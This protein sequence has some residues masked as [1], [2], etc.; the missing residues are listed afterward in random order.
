[1]SSVILQRK[2][3][4]AVRQFRILGSE[5]AAGIATESALIERAVELEVLEGAARR[6]AGGSGAVV[7]LEA[8][9]GLGKTALLES[10]A[11]FAAQAGCLVR[12]AAPSPL[13]RHFPFG[14]V[15]ALLEAPLRDAS[16]Q[17][18][19][20]LLRGAGA[21]AGGLLLDGIVPEDAATATVAHSVL[22]LCTAIAQASP[23][24]LIVDDAQWADRSSLAVLSHLARR[25]EDV[26][27]L[28]V[29]AAR[30]EYP[31]AATDLLSLL[32]AVRSATVL[33][34]QRL[35]P[36]GAVRLIH[37]LAPDTPVQACCDCHRAVDGNPWLLAELARQIATSGLGAISDPN[38]DAWPVTAV[39][40][41]TVRRRLAELALSERAAAAALA[42]TGEEATPQ[43][44]ASTAGLTVSELGE[45]WH[46]LAAAGLLASGRRQFAHNL[47][48][49]AIREDLP[50]GD[51]ERLHRQA[52]RAL[53]EA[54]APPETAARHLLHCGPQSDA[55][56]SGLLWQAASDA[57]ERGAPRA[58]ARYLERAVDERALGDDRGRMLAQLATVT[59]DAG[60]PDSA[61]WLREAAREPWDR[62][63]RVDILT[64]LAALGVAGG[65]AADVQELLEEQLASETDPDAR[66]ALQTAS[67]DALTTVPGS[68]GERIRRVQA[69]DAAAISDSSQGRAVLA[70]RA[71]LASELGA[72]DA[73]A[74]S[75]LALEALG[76]GQ[77]LADAWRRLAGHLCVRVLTMTDRFD[78]A[79]AAIESISRQATNR[80]SLRLRAAAAWYTAE[81]DLRTGQIADAEEHA[82]RAL[83]IVGEDVNAVTGGAVEVLVCTLAER[84][85][86]EQAD[87]LL[88]ERGLHGEIGGDPWEI[89]VLHARARLWLAQGDFERA[90]ADATAAGALRERQGRPNPTWTP[91]RSTASLALS[92][93]GRCREARE[94]AD[95]ELALATRFG[96]PVAVARAMHAR[97][98]AESDDIERV[99]LCERALA[100]VAGTPAGL[101]T[102]RL[103]LE[104]GSTLAY[105]GR[106][107]EARGALRP[108]L[109]D[110]DAV[111]AALLAGRARRELVATGLRPR[112][113]ALEG[114][115]ALTPR[116]RQIC[117]LAAAGKA[118]RAIA[119]ELFLSIKT[120]ETHLA[121]GYRKLGVSTRSELAG[122]LA[123]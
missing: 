34:P 1:M 89:G 102:V 75:T 119:H 15:R 109:A 60:L 25:I 37:R 44:V 57:A 70:H 72:P 40:R 66:A 41:N 110:A 18:R 21:I 79:R 111:G 82:R 62:A 68:Q 4:S 108:A 42:V 13:E 91:W 67:L 56:V 93:L 7:V 118:N 122:E 29:V 19:A 83:E 90:H 36:S 31:G 112:R 22:W 49:A 23:L 55:E 12:R 47:I 86:F 87:Q 76:E 2:R 96:A 105:L 114:A 94:L 5:A 53:S 120:V 100:L 84:G 123:P 9:P 38:P 30:G 16:A 81:L 54:G 59:F 74:C 65:G 50:A 14:A 8:P 32:G 73:S 51:R 46:A 33:H 101:E 85:A 80:G 64:R 26:P 10:A 39:A 43:V 27:L 45:A 35:T 107:I 69:I 58:A 98:V 17:Q 97:A 99:A 104:L 48:A 52:A 11:Q 88:R 24:A 117:E 106:R 61:R 78:H 3:P 121:A 20:Q 28:I 77:L 103:R 6:T 113:A 63:S 115:E 71:W 116:Q 95:T 92:H